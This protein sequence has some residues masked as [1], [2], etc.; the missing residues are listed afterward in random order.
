MLPRK[1]IGGDA[2]GLPGDGARRRQHRSSA[3]G[4]ARRAGCVRRLAVR[5]PLREQNL[6]FVDRGLAAAATDVVLLNSDTIVT[7]GWLQRLQ[8]CAESAPEVGIVCPP[9]NKAT[10]LSV[11]AMNLNDSLSAGLSLEGPAVDHGWLKHWRCDRSD[12]V[13]LSGIETLIILTVFSL[14]GDTIADVTLLERD[15]PV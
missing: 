10:I 11:R 13:D 8:A 3:D 1:R 9:S 6:G 5:T 7:Q 15:S 4:L 12:L 2:G 14:L